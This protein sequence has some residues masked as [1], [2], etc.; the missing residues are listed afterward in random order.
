MLN[1]F[2]FREYILCFRLQQQFP[3]NIFLYRTNY[4][5][6]CYNLEIILLILLFFFSNP[7]KKKKEQQQEKRR[8][9]RRNRRRTRTRRSQTGVFTLFLSLPRNPLGGRFVKG[10]VTEVV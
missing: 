3:I 4:T 10:E 2:I 7:K 8:Q 9:R 6:L 5:D 1:N